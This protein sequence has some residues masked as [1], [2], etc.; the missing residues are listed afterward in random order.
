[1]VDLRGKP[2]GADLKKP[3]ELSAEQR[4][5]AVD[6]VQLYEQFVELQKER[7]GYRGGLHWK[8]VGSKEYLVQ[9]LNREGAQ[10]SL[11][12]RASETEQKYR[13]FVE[14]KR[15][16]DRRLRSTGEEIRRRARFCVAAAV[17]RVP[18]LSADIVRLLDTN[19]LLGTRL[20]ILGSHAMYAY[21]MAA[22][23]QLAS[24]LLQTDDLDTLLHTKHE[25]ELGGSVRSLGLL[26]ILKKV[27]KTFELA[28]PSSFRAVNA[29][30]FMVD[31]IRA[32]L[33]S[34]TGVRPTDKRLETDLIADPLH[35][36]EW[37]TAVPTITQV[38]IAE[39][40]FPLRFVV[41]EPRVF[42]LH[43]LWLSLQPTRNPIK[44]KRDFRQA[45]AIARLA[46]DY[47]NL[48]F[49]DQSLNALPTELTSMVPG[50]L[51]RLRTGGPR[52]REDH[53]ELP[54]GFE[55]EHEE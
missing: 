21:E 43:K 13:T 51:A 2:P 46:I 1:M 49:D 22:G 11:G 38:V 17:N 44:R 6:A 20:V 42:A 27:D 31:L 4:R 14:R 37:L 41:P 8:K 50:L 24:G 16:L 7:Q 55:D 54:A 26:A 34:T 28:R 15:A 25:L 10:K 23:V 45:E 32:P 33:E 3:R 18:T 12:P 39:N 30:G 19:G 48:Q 40:G 5:I 29:K 36:L 9:T 47:L 52:I 35:G 53:A